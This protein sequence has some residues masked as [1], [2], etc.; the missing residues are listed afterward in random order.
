MNHADHSAGGMALLTQAT[1]FQV[2]AS[3]GLHLTLEDILP[4]VSLSDDISTVPTELICLEN[5]LAGT[6]F[7]QSEIV[8]IAEFAREHVIGMHLDGA[9]LW[10]VAAE[11]MS[12]RGLDPTSESALQQV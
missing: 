12:E 3:N 7:P 6:V 5:T 2:V 1:T 11:V 9:S 10:N 4:H 8:R